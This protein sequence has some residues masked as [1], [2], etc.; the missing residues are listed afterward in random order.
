MP[1]E[2]MAYYVRIWNIT[3]IMKP[4]NNNNIINSTTQVGSKSQP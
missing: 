4:V 3:A 2:S 1:Q